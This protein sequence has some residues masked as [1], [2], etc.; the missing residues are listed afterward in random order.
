MADNATLRA[1]DLIPLRSRVSWGAI[2]AG[3]VIALAV[4][5]ILTLL[6]GAIGLTVS[7]NVRSGTLGTGAAIWAILAT[8]VAL[9]LGGWVTSQ[10]TVGENKTEA[11]VHGVIMWGVVLFMVL[12]LVSTGMRAGFN[13]MWGV[14]SFTNAAAQ[15]TTADDW[16]AAARRNN[17]PQ[18]TINEWKQKAKDAPRTV[19]EAAKDPANQQAAAEY[20]TQATW[21]TLLGTLLSMAAAVVGALVG[22]GPSFRLLA[23]PTGAVRSRYETRQYAG[24]P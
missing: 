11:V 6:G 18:E 16:E 20:A 17:V 13:A 4:Y 23:I 12:W 1:E 3:A 19:A 2:F 10:C 7:D 5:L 14:A 9:F 24:Q 21:Y 22:A 8:G 15:N